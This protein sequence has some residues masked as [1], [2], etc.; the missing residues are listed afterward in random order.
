M[1]HFNVSP[2][3][4]INPR[5]VVTLTLRVALLAWIGIFALVYPFQRK[6]LFVPLGGHVT[7]EAAG[8]VGVSEELV[9]TP[10]GERLVVWASA[11]KPGLPT[12]FYFHGNAGGP[13]WRADRFQQFQAAGYG[14]R[15]LAYRGFGG[16]TG[17]PSER[18]L[19]T[20]A[21][22]TYDHARADGLDAREIILFGESLGTGVAVQLAASRPTAGVILDSPYTSTADVGARRFPYLPVSW[23]MWDQFNSRAHIAHMGA[24]LLIL[25]GDRDDIVP[26]DL[27]VELFAAAVEPKHFLSLPG[28]YHTAPLQRGGWAA[29]VPFIDR[30]IG[31][32]DL[33]KRTALE[34]APTSPR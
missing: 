4:G 29:I 15:V 1:L 32:P 26:Y 25:H 9:A 27:G 10:D 19:I 23:L 5:R 24:P 34:R 2:R 11:A 31:R 30:A 13:S 20:D 22:A 14:L 7:P 21:I 6:L 18:G 33:S 17:S 3:R 16:S 8:L 12:I 28:E